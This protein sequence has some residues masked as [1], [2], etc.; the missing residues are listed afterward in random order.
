MWTNKLSV[1]NADIDREHQQL[2]GLLD[3]FY[4]GIKEGS[5]KLKLQELIQGLL[6][7]TRVHFAREEQYMQRI[8]Y[9]HLEHHR[10]QHQMFINKANEFYDKITNGKLILSLEVTNFLKNWLV[11]HIKGADQSYAKY[12][13]QNE[14]TLLQM[15]YNV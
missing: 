8:Q 1:G 6:D 5:P 14:K 15:S 3:D 13:T 12:V 10:E 9:P 2:F 7:Y 11:E 4:Q